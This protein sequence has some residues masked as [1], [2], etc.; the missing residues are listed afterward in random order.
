MGIQ[1]TGNGL[2]GELGHNTV[3]MVAIVIQEA[4]DLLFDSSRDPAGEG[5]EEF[6]AFVKGQGGVLE[7]RVELFDTVFQDL[8][9]V[10]R[11][12]S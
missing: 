11:R 8:T 7:G 2:P 9:E 12:E 4:V 3:E 5:G 10:L 6:L 1:H